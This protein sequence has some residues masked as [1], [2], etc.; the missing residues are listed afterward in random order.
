MI[1]LDM[2]CSSWWLVGLEG[3]KTWLET[4]RT[5]CITWPLWSRLVVCMG[6]TVL[7]RPIEGHVELYLTCTIPYILPHFVTFPCLPITC[8]FASFDILCSYRYDSSIESPW[9]RFY[10][11]YTHAII[12]LKRALVA[13]YQ[14]AIWLDRFQ[15]ANGGAYEKPRRKALLRATL[16]MD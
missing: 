12:R 14:V 5:L 8:R 3:L 16:F 1:D 15:A 10:H 11:D 13:K 4:K 6:I 2:T 9:T 7:G